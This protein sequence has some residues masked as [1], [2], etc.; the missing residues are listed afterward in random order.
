MARARAV[1]WENKA[2]LFAPSTHPYS[3]PLE[4][5]PMAFGIIAILRVHVNARCRPSSKPP[6]LGALTSGAGQEGV[7]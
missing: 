5:S 2:H 4:G 1:G 7:Q 6:V 3:V